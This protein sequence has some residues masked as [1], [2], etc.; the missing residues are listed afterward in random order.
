MTN[1]FATLCNA[2]MLRYNMSIKDFLRTLGLSKN[3][4]Y[5]YCNG[6]LPRVDKAIRI[7]R[8]MKC[9]VEDVWG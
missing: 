8:V 1:K 2:H 7:A 9:K 4:Y 3:A 6:S 5:D